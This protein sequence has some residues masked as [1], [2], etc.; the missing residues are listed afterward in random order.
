MKV[1]HQFI[2]EEH[3][4]TYL[5]DQQSRT[6]YSIT[7]SLDAREYEDLMN[8]G[9]RKFGAVFFKPVCKACQQCQSLRVDAAAFKP[10]RS[11]RRAWKKNAD[12]QVKYGDPRVD[13]KRLELYRRYHEVQ[14]KRK[15]WPLEPIGG[16]EYAS[17]FIFNPVPDV[18]ISIWRGEQLCGVILT[19]VTPNTVSAIYHYHDPELS[20]RSLGTYCVLLSIDL[21]NRLRKKWAYLGYYVAGCG[22]LNY[23]ARYKPCELLGADGIWR[24]LN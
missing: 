7:S 11:Q 17:S 8:A 4:C 6:E 3:S 20:E 9:Y 19:E 24:P 16:D 21:A 15:Q 10:D 5:P 13:V 22:S 12:L 14:A 2:S 23:K 1:L 18:E